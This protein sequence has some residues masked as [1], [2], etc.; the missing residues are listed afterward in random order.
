VWETE[1]GGLVATVHFFPE[2]I[3][4]EPRSGHWLSWQRCLVILFILSRW[5]LGLHL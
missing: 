2:G 4:F 1:L 5:M 3:P